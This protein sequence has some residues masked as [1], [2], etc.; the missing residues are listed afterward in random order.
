M[1]TERYRL[2]VHTEKG[3]STIVLFDHHV[4]PYETRNIAKERPEIVK[5]LMPLL[6]K[7]NTG[8]LSDFEVD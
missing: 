7:G 8:I 2:I 4:D 1:R 3:T 5:R 6:K